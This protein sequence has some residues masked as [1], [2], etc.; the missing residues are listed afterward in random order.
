MEICKC[1][2]PQKDGLRGN[3][4][5]LK[6]FQSVCIC[7]SQAPIH[8]SSDLCFFSYKICATGSL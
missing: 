4:S 6:I 2:V 3:M 5:Y 8:V 7:F 1:V